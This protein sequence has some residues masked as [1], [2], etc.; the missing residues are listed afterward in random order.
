LLIPLPHAIIT[1]VRVVM[2]NKNDTAGCL[3]LYH[4]PV[5]AVLLAVPFK[6]GKSA[7]KM[8]QI[9]RIVI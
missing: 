6:Y 8:A 3:F 7:N 2:A 4:N 5:F 1:K 9:V